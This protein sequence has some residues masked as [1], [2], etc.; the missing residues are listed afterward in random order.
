M[1]RDTQRD[2]EADAERASAFF[3][4]EPAGT[5]GEDNA[6]ESYPS[7]HPA[8]ADTEEANPQ[9]ILEGQPNR[10][11]GVEY[12]TGGHKLPANWLMRIALIWSGYA[13]SA[14]AGNAGSY[15]GIWFVTESTGSPLALALLYVLAFLPMGLLSPLGGVIA[16]KHNRKAIIIICDSI[17]AANGI[18]MAAVTW[19][20]GPNFAAVAAFCGV[21]G[22]T[23]AF[24]GPAFNATMPLL[25]PVRHLMRINSMD[26]LLG[27]ISMI[28]A[29]ALG[30]LLYTSFGLE[31]SLLLGGLG[32]LAAVVTMFLAKI[33]RLQAIQRELGPWASLKEG[34]RALS[35][36]RG[37]LILTVGVSLGMLAYGPI[38]SLL[39]LMVSQHFHGDGFAAS[40][41]AAV[42]GI[43]MLAGSLALMVVNPTRKLA[44]IIVA[45]SL[46][47]GIS[48]FASGFIPQ[49]GYWL[50]VG[51]IGVLAIACAWFNAPLMTLLQK[52]IPEEK[53]GRVI[54]LF[55][56][57]NGLAIPVGTA[58]GGVTA[59]ITG[60]PLFF[61]IDG[62][63]IIALGLAIAFSKHVRAL[64]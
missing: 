31:A 36:Q 4:Q 1:T 15:A 41:L 37:L 17:L 19:T 13:V 7:R 64:K 44:R 26:T 40:L 49:T 6:R 35:A 12:A 53:L 20:I 28:A 52:G 42:M 54:G 38:D 51:C 32:S 2:F 57:M 45:S 50:F 27:S 10:P 29:P 55:T 16:D 22:L 23:S 61:S 25:V 24:R 11:D 63:F 46:I 58:L 39:P 43:G 56:A 47:V 8:A 30:I 59:E 3:F 48:A 21:W 14:F 62:A 60:T 18:V 5:P 34:A 9:S 33:P